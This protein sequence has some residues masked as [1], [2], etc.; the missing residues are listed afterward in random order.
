MAKKQGLTTS[1]TM[2]AAKRLVR[3][4]L[5][6]RWKLYVLSIF[7]M[8]GTAAF[9]GAL[10]YSTKLI[11]NDV[12][13]DDNAR[14]AINVALLVIGVSLAKS[15]FSY[16]NAVIAV[17]FDRSVSADFQ[18]RIFRKLIELDVSHFHNDHAATQPAKLKLFGTAS[19]KAMIGICNKMTTDTLTLI[20]L[21]TVML[22][23]DPV[24]TA[25]CSLMIPIIFGF[26]AILSRRVREAAA[27]ET[28]LTGGFFAIGSEAIQGIKTVKS[29][30]LEEKTV[31]RFEEAVDTL[32]QKMFGIAKTTSATVPLMELLGGIVIGLFV[33]YA[34]WQ[35]ITYGKTPGEF[36]AFIT[37]FLMA[38]A[39]AERLSKIWVDLQKKLVQVH[40]MYALL[41]EEVRHKKDGT[42]PLVG[43]TP[44]IRF[45]DVS[46][47]YRSA[48]PALRDV[49]FEIK[50]GERIA[51]VGRSGAGKSTLID[52]LQ[53]FYTATS[54]QIAL[55][56]L[57]ITS[58]QNDSLRESIALI[59]QDVFLFDGSLADNIRDGHPLASEA[60]ILSAVHAAQLEGVVDDLPKGVES[61]I[62]P[63]GGNL[64]G[65]QRQRVGIARAIVK[66]AKIYIFDEATS[67]LDS[68][69]ERAIMQRVVEA[70]PDATLIFVTHRPSTLAYVDRA[71]VLSNGRL[72]A[73]DTPDALRQENGEFQ[74]L[75]KTT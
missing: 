66:K 45:D 56:D 73:F 55:G 68:A 39:P 34:A 38:Y 33:M 1:D 23:Q 35:T 14:A 12:F 42:T 74:E 43:D 24:M 28:A 21:F 51:I 57:D 59:S 8:V 13:V 4:T 3:D 41:D 30:Q 40:T 52:L 17:L 2:R 53:R 63:N 31:S 60:D 61:G 22:L 71:M 75:F 47:S 49:S 9:T 27:A 6:R 37:A 70:L 15:I 20:A 44:A 72:A 19:G 46:F 26:V 50:P 32:Q 58:I 29:F 7:C 54:G 62:G 65:G 25:A 5:P 69:N 11:V 36:T 18:K 16:A 48:K 10:A 67:A 64:S